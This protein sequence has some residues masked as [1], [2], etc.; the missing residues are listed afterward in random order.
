MIIIGI[1]WRTA[2]QDVKS[3]RT[4]IVNENASFVESSLRERLAVYED[5][6]RAA[7]GLFLSSDTVNRDE[8]HNF[9]DSL[10]LANRYPGIRGLGFITLIPATD[11]PIL[12]AS[13][14]AE[15]L[16]SYAIHPSSDQ[17]VLAPLLYLVPLG[18]TGQADDRTSPALGFDMYSD[19]LR[20]QAMQAAM[21]SGQPTLTG[22][23]NLI[24]V[25]TTPPSRGFLMY[26]PLYKKN[27]PIDTVEQRATAIDGFFYAPFVTG[28]AFT[29]LFA[30]DAKTSP[31]F[32][33]TI[34]D[35]APGVDTL[36]FQS[37][38][39]INDKAFF[40]AKRSTL[41]LYGQDWTIVYRIK[42][43]IVPGAVR[44]RPWSALLGGGI[45]AAALA[46]VIYLLIQ[47]RTRSLA[48]TEQKKL[49]EAKDELLS[50]ASHQLRTPATAVKQYVLMVKDGFA[51]VLSSE[52]RKLLQ[53][54]YES[55]ERQLTIVDD[56]LYV[57]RIDAGKATLKPE[58]VDIGELV[59]SVMRDQRTALKARKQTVVFKRSRKPILLQADPHYVR[60]ILENLLSNASKYSYERTKIA[61]MVRTVRNMVQI[62]VTDKGVGI[63]PADFPDVFLKFS[64]IP[65]ELTRQTPGSG[66][67]LYLAR[68]LAL[69]HGGDITFSSVPHKGST[70][71]VRLPKQ[72]PGGENM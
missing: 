53:L 46:A 8:W 20:I 61:F 56:L 37:S 52:Q 1:S 15:G 27:V 45:F 65:N 51:G 67:G 18:G 29:S 28:S 42:Q 33:F 64:R 43:D 39:A 31:S 11:K 63:D 59:A 71:V 9:V 10:Q 49:E 69:L 5:S 41:S 60:M 72:Q 40:E 6:L 26:M 36:L 35:G 16:S 47:R 13:V 66:I 70:F 50:L 14:Q 24:S 57:A 38:G 55:N 2:W 21:K 25:S 4:T 23:V 68:Q 48:Y 7:N 44:T 22:I 19:P 62:S 17:S 34:Y 3:Q 32:G 58:L 54:A 30:N 12:E